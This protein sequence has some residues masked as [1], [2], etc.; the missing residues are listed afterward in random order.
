MALDLIHV[1]ENDDVYVAKEMFTN[2]IFMKH[3]KTLG[4]DIV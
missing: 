4:C 1:I 3:V 2:S